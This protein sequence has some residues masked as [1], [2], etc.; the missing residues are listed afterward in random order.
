MQR[1][2]RDRFFFG[3]LFDDGKW[4]LARDRKQNKVVLGSSKKTRLK[5]IFSRPGAAVSV[6]A[7]AN[8]ARMQNPRGAG[9]GRRGCCGGAGLLL[10]L[11]GRGNAWEM[12]EKEEVGEGESRKRGSERS[13]SRGNK[14]DQLRGEVRAGCVR[15]T[16]C[17]EWLQ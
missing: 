10:Q 1:Q 11:D 13:E 4:A 5:P 6:F 7:L 12:M 2:K 3:C 16:S 17:G 14:P 9:G 15:Y 8:G